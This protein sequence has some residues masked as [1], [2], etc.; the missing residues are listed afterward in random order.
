MT[1]YLPKGETTSKRRKT[2]RSLTRSRS[3]IRRALGQLSRY[4]PDPL[5]SKTCL[6]SSYVQLVELKMLRL[7][8][9]LR[10]KPSWWT[11]YKNPEIRAKWRAEALAHDVD[12][13]GLTEAEVDYVLDELAGY[14]EMRDA[15]TGIQ[16]GYETFSLMQ[17]D[18]CC[19]CSIRASPG[20]TS[21][22][23]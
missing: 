21:P 3:M 1:S 10:S 14:D 4:V 16:V 7:S 20:S 13:Q 15:E 8:Y 17:A 19:V 11:K 12:G 22:I 6:F 23:H 18:A 9:A 5:Y 2:G